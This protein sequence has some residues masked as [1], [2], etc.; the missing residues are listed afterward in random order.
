MVEHHVKNIKNN[1]HNQ[2][3]PHIYIMTKWISN[4][5]KLL[6]IVVVIKLYAR[7]DIFN[8][9]YYLLYVEIKDY[10]VKIDGKNFFDQPIDN[11]V[12]TYENIRKIATGQEDDYTIGCLLDYP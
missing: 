7:I 3:L 8:W 9:D 10:N 4:I 2:K 1:K 11:D 6:F 12:K 5:W